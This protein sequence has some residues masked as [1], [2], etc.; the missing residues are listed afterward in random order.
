[1]R[2]GRKKQKKKSKW[3]RL[4]LEKDGITQTVSMQMGK[5]IGMLKVA[6]KLGSFGKRG[7]KLKAVSGDSGA[8]GLF[9][10][11]LDGYQTGDPVP[12]KKMVKAAGLA[13]T[14]KFIKRLIK[15]DDEKYK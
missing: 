7:W 14:P 2:L 15:K 6:K 5:K 3:V 1:M 13:A 10:S 11:V 12:I 9:N 4:E 8:V